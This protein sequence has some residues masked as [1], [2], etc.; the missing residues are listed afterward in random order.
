MGF[1]KDH[2]KRP[3]RPV[4]PILFM[5]VRLIG[6]VGRLDWFEDMFD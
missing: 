2:E 1:W 5:F 3:R 6:L 4:W